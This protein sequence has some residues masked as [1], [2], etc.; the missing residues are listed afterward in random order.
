MI[1]NFQIELAICLMVGLQEVLAQLGW[2]QFLVAELRSLRA[3]K[4]GL[5]F[6]FNLSK[7]LIYLS[8]RRCVVIVGRFDCCLLATSC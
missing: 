7:Q 6:L 4:G 5:V 3:A 1:L 2:S 8:C